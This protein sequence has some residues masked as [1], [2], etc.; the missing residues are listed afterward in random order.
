MCTK[1]LWYITQYSIHSL[2]PEHRASTCFLH[3]S[4]TV[5]L[6]GILRDFLDLSLFSFRGVVCRVPWYVHTP[7]P[8][9]HLRVNLPLSFFLFCALPQH[10]IGYFVW[11]MY[12]KDRCSS[13]QYLSLTCFISIYCYHHNNNKYWLGVVVS[14][15]TLLFQNKL[16]QP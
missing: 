12:A 15:F 3:C 1:N 6:S 13:C 8:F 16:V 14:K 2:L 11:S 10:N 9:C 4:V 5:L 7:T